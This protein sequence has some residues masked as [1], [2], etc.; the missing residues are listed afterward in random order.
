MKKKTTIEKWMCDWIA[1]TQF[2]PWFVSKKLIV[3]QSK[4]LNGKQKYK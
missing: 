1:F 4:W 2:E 3:Q